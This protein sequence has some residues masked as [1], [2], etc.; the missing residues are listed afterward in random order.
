MLTTIRAKPEIW[1]LCVTRFISRPIMTQLI[2]QLAANAKLH[3][4]KGTTGRRTK[5]KSLK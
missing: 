3:K 4:V 2:E 5:K 1:S